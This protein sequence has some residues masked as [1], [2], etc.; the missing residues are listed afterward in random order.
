MKRL[1]LLGCLIYACSFFV[2]AD[3]ECAL[4]L[5]E[6]KSNYNAGNYQ[7]AK[8]LYNYIVSECGESYGNAAAMLRQCEE[9]L[10]PKLSVSRSN[11]SV[12]A[13]SGSTMLSVTSNRH[14]E[15]RNTNSNMFSVYKN[16]N[17]ITINY[18]ANSSSS[19]RSDYFDVVT[20][21]GSKSVRITISQ[22]AA[23]IAST[24]SV[25][26]TSI[27]C[28]ASATTEYITVNCN[29]NWEIQYPTGTM[30][31]AT[32]SGN[33]VK[34]E[35]SANSATSSRTDYFYIKTADGSKTQKISL[36]QYGKTS[37]SS[38]NAYATI[39]KAWIEYNVYE[40]G[41]KGMRVHV[42]FDAYGVLKHKVGIV[43]H[44]SNAAGEELKDYNGKYVDTGGKVAHSDNTTALYTNTTWN[45]FTLFFPYSELHISSGSKNINLTAEIGVYDWTTNMWLSANNYTV[46]FSFSN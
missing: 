32:R 8:G 44:F 33:M 34:V 19:S 27:S 4:T 24:L 15:L 30:Y 23:S 28:S 20:A 12:G 21:D 41:V 11:I 40:N 7:K 37:A 18:Y 45:D 46:T 9:M 29:T 6:A 2:Y 43:L 39:H 5:Q 35:I 16:G 26:R 14:W 38:Y 36:T 10:T 42:K 1:I 22:S 31:R 17:E 3:D 13:S 25:S